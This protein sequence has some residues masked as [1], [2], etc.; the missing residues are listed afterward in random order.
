[1]LTLIAAVNKRGVIGRDGHL[2]W[3]DADDMYRFKELTKGRICLVGR[4]TWE[5]LPSSFFEG[6]E[7]ICISSDPKIGLP[8]MEATLKWPDAWVI[9]GESVY[10]QAIE[11]GKVKYYHLSLIDDNSFGDTF[12]PKIFYDR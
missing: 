11:S 1:M 3:R 7:V 5:N 2:P 8:F 9:G 10:R 12:L 6:R 4:T